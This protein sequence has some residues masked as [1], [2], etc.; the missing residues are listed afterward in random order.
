MADFT[1]K[2]IRNSYD[3]IVQFNS[4][5]LTDAL[6]GALSASIHRLTV[7]TNLVVSGSIR[8]EEIIV[9]KTSSS[10]IF[11]SGSNQFGDSLDDKQYMTGSVDITGSLTVN[12]QTFAGVSSS[13]TTLSSSFEVVKAKTLVSSS[14]QIASEISGSFTIASG[15]LASRIASQEAF[16]S[17]IDSEYA[18]DAQ[19]AT[20][21]SQLNLD[22]GSYAVTGSNIFDADQSISAS[23]V[24]SQSITL[25][26]KI[27][28]GEYHWNNTFPKV[29]D[30]SNRSEIWFEQN[31]NGSDGGDMVFFRSRGVPGAETVPQVGDNIFTIAGRAMVSGSSTVRS[32]SNLQ[33]GDFPGVSAIRST[34]RQIGSGS[35]G[36]DLEF[37]TAPSGF[38]NT[39]TRLTIT[40]EGAIRASG[41]F[42]S[43]TTVH[44]R[45]GIST[46]A[47]ATAS[48]G[49]VSAS[50]VQAETYRNVGS[51]ESVIN[52]ANN[53]TLSSSNAVVVSGAPFRLPSFTNAQTGSY[54]FGNGDMIYNTDRNKFLGYANGAFVEL[55]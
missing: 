5:S 26:D 49:F 17:S 12:G 33:I 34:I 8:A 32:G 28:I 9:T 43:E 31:R 36:A 19:L 18:T 40:E 1:G 42:H 23:L 37:L 16:S 47:S 29:H 10:V 50:V 22:T 15:G 51:G 54:T 2:Q 45:T 38:F 21:V 6:G 27:K 7:D 3:R 14:N 55:H 35:A 25:G 4:G 11:Q 46:A 24:V 41:S 13:L 20:A 48:L 52:S 53:L 39:K 44:G 30:K